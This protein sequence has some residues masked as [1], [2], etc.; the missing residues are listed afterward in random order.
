MATVLVP[1]SVAL[2]GYRAGLAP[3]R[4]YARKGRQ[5]DA[6]RLTNADDQATVRK[7][8]PK[9]LE[10]LLEA[11]PIMDVSEAMVVGDSVL[12]PSRI[13]IEPPKE[14]PLSATIDFWSRW[15]EDITNPDF[16]IAVENMRRQSRAKHH[17]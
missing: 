12:L 3:I 16:S 11:L 14:K 2:I 8:L 4:F 10:S 17:S 13:K 5:I 1:P 7:L 9:S 6:I 15:Q